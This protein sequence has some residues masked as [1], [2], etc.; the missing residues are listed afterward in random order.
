[1]CA[2]F[3]AY[4]PAEVTHPTLR[5]R[6]GGRW[7][8]SW[9]TVTVLVVGGAAS[10][11]SNQ[12]GSFGNWVAIVV[13]ATLVMLA[14][15]GLA[16]ATVL[17]SREQRPVPVA[18]VIAVGVVAGLARGAA[19]LLTADALGVALAR[20]WW[21]V[22]L[23]TAMM[24]GVT[25][26]GLA[27]VLDDIAR[28]RQ[29]R[30]ALRGRLIV[31][32]EREGERLNLS[33]ALTDAA[34]AEMIDALADA[35]ERIEVP[36]GSE[37][38][39]ERLA[40]ADSLR[41]MVD[42]TLRP[43]SHRLYATGRI[44]PDA[45]Q[46]WRALRAAFRAQPVFPLATAAVVTLIMTPLAIS[47]IGGIVVGAV[48]FVVL[49]VVRA[50]ARRSARIAAHE[51][52]TALLSLGVVSAV[53]A[54][55]LRTIVGD[56]FA[57]TA[58]AAGGIIPIALLV[59]TSSAMT[60]LRGEDVLT[61]SLEEEVTAR[62]VDGL[63]ADREL[64]RAS[65]DLAQHVHGTLQSHL[66]STA[67]VIERAVEAGDDA[68]FARAVEQA[69]AALQEMPAAH[70]ASA[71][72]GIRDEVEDAASL[73]DGFM[74]V[75]VEIAQGLDALP[76]GVVADVGRVVGEGLGNAWKH[77][78][79]RHARIT[80]AAPAPDT[81]M[82]RVTDDGCAPLGGV[83]GMGSA[84]LDFVAPGSWSLTAAPGGGSSLEV[85]L[86]IASGVPMGLRS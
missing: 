1:M 78:R 41:R 6:I 69:R 50:L 20:P 22:L 72:L 44:E 8:L 31:L 61:E 49:A 7:A 15:L 11:A 80:V 21:A 55:A 28:H 38:S 45:R 70:D 13:P 9:V 74:Q 84:W 46:S 12:P 2:W 37:T 62:E 81:V 59:I 5:D 36:T 57:L 65:R 82:V 35:R 51:F 10:T 24:T 4:M 58:I 48:T 16:Q 17:R 64:A 14:A 52:P 29:R 27:L 60:A 26:P 40:M 32:R 73:W 39:E 43:L 18:V 76:H 19:V 54:V 85:H 63:V 67:F 56:G 83:P 3:H 33:D 75:D 25:V 23:A 86:V 68:A 42:S 30:A 66:L 34:Y 77:G 79:A 47:P 53:V 71:T